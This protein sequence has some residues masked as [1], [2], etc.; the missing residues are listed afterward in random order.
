[1]SETEQERQEAT[2]ISLPVNWHFSEGL[3]SRYANNVL[4]QIGQFEFIISFFEMQQPLLLG[5][6]EENKAKLA[7]IGEIQAECVGK[8]IVPHELVPAI[9]SVLQ[10]EYDKFHSSKSN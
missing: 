1:M 8:I 4:V 5:T 9:I 6:P 7:S 3:Q 2:E 10:T